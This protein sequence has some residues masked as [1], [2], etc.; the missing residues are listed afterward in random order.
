MDRLY[1]KHYLCSKMKKQKK[2]MREY[3]NVNI[4]KNDKLLNCVIAKL[5]Y[6]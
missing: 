4:V 6:L 3:I 2:K 5:L 1:L